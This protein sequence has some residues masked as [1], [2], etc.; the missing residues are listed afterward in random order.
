MAMLR[1]LGFHSSVIRSYRAYLS[2]EELEKVLKEIPLEYVAKLRIYISRGSKFFGL[3]DEARIYVDTVDTELGKPFVLDDMHIDID[4]VFEDEVIGSDT[5]SM[6]L[7]IVACKPKDLEEECTKRF[8]ARLSDAIE[9]AK[10]LL[11]E[12]QS[13][14]IEL[15]Y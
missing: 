15:G 11:R 2:L 9:T 13:I 8:C 7:K 14:T 4:P 5:A 1:A 3:S 10:Q 12:Y 6:M